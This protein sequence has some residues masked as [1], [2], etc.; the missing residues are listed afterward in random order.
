MRISAV[1][2]TCFQ[3]S[4]FF[5]SGCAGELHSGADGGEHTV[6]AA[7]QK[8]GDPNTMELPFQ[9]LLLIHGLLWKEERNFHLLYATYIFATV[10][11]PNLN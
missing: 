10:A 2:R 3:A 8:T 11:K 6:W 1:E 5:H 9:A 4:S 7:R